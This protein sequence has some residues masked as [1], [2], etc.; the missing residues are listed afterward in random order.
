VTL[1]TALYQ[2]TIDN[3]GTIAQAT[4]VPLNDAADCGREFTQGFIIYKSR[5]YVALVY[6]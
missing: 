5:L 3:L 2:T 1:P 4:T 6:Q